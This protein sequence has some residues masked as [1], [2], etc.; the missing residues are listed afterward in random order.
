MSSVDEPTPTPTSRDSGSESLPKDET[1]RLTALFGPVLQNLNQ[2]VQDAA[3]SQVLLRQELD[4]VLVAVKELK[5]L[6]DDD[7]MATVLEEKSKKL[8]SLKRR[9]TLVHTILQTC[10]ERTKKLCVSHKP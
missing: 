1:N 9:L 6:S 2:S 10:N 4:Q 3:S 5:E 7:V 8:L